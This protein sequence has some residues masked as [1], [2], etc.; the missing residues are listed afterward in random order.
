MSS[1]GGGGGMIQDGSAEP[2][3]PACVINIFLI[4]VT[5]LL[6]HGS[7]LRQLSETPEV[8][9]SA[10]KWPLSALTSTRTNTSHGNI[11]I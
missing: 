11:T 8:S 4:R 10:V 5:T 3:L 2:V 9:R 7:K 6:Q 1:S